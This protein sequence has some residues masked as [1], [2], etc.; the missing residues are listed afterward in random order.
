MKAFSISAVAEMLGLSFGLAAQAQYK[1]PSQYFPKNNPGGQPVAP[2]APT[3]PQP[4]KFK[5]LP[6]NTQFYFVSDTNRTY[7]WMKISSNSA[8]NTKNGVTQ[9]IH[10]ETP[11]Q[12]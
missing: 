12:R 7:A 1:S 4:P 3:T 9:V 11:I 2:R 10:G 8:T 6:L 5:D